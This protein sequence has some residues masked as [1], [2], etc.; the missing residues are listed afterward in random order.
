MIF[1]INNTN[2]TLIIFSVINTKLYLG[3]VKATEVFYKDFIENSSNILAI[4]SMENEHGVV[5]N[6]EFYIP[7]YTAKTRFFITSIL[8]LCGFMD[9]R[10]TLVSVS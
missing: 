1:V 7:L 6:F 8:S 3:V 2:C 9:C 10:S 4:Y 5:R